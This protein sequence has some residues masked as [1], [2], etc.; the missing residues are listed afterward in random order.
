MTSRTSPRSRCASCAPLFGNPEALRPTVTRQELTEEAAREF[1]ALAIALRGRGHAPQAVAHFLDQLL[2]CMFAEDAGLLPRGI[3]ERL[4]EATRADP[5]GFTEQLGELFARMGTHGGGYF[6]SERIEWFN[7]SLFDGSPAIP[8]AAS[9]VDI[10]RRVAKLDW[11]EIEPA[12]FGT[13]F[14]RGLDPGRRTQLGAHYT[15]R[16]SIE[17]LVEPVLMAPLRAEYAAMQ[18]RVQ[19]LIGQGYGIGG[20]KRAAEA[21]ERPPQGVRVLPGPPA[22]GHRARPRVRLGQLPVHGA[23]VAQGPG[24]RGDPLG[25]RSRCASAPSTRRSGPHQLRGIELNPYAAELARVTIWIGE[26]QWMLRNGFAYARDPILRPLAN[27][28]TRTPSSTRATRHSPWRPAGRT[29]RSSSATRR[30]WVASCCAP[31]S[32]TPTSTP[33]SGS[34]RAGSRAR[35]TS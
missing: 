14:E 34:T 30:S 28:E 4:T 6:G 27:I 2:F 25:R 23:P 12:I 33:C 17:R 9:E 20:W 1:A 21:R 11:A 19:E 3:I 29:P 22:H 18:A 7:G 35:R 8:L 15:D 31:T 24:A 13:L 16:A 32:A 26:I 5:D 10:I